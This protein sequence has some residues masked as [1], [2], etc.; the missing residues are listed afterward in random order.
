MNVLE[1]SNRI[2]IPLEEIKFS[3]VKSSGP[4]GQNVNKT[5]T[6]AVL[7]W[8]FLKNAS[9]E[10]PIRNRLMQRLKSHLNE[11]GEITLMS[12]QFR[13][14]G[15]NREVCLNKLKNLL[16]KASFVQKKRVKTTPSKNAK[17]KRLEAKKGHSL[18]KKSRQKPSLD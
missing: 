9:I 5:N 7:K 18:K 3:Y 1:V 8:D 16:L 15:Q 10:G 4:G 12:D 17:K 14:Q 11:R 2:Q 6:K 13:T